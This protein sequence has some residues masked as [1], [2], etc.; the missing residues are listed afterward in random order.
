MDIKVQKNHLEAMTQNVTKNIDQIN[1]AQYELEAALNHSIIGLE[2]IPMSDVKSSMAVFENQLTQI[3]SS[4]NETFIGIYLLYALIL[5]S[6]NQ[7]YDNRLFIELHKIQ[8][9]NMLCA[10]IVLF[11]TFKTIC[12]HNMC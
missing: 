1:L 7:L 8:V 11:L 12:V 2:K 3:V 6:I 4:Q 9:Q 10:Q 5:A